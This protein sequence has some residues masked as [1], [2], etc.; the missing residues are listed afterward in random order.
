MERAA[1]TQ[2]QADALITLHEELA[3]RVRDLVTVAPYENLASSCDA[4]RN[5]LTIALTHDPASVQGPVDCCCQQ[6]DHA[7]IDARGVCERLGEAIGKR[8]PR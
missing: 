5:R 2:L 3:Y 4:V 8:A 6:R 1:V 7:H